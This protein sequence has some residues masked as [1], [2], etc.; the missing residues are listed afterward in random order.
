MMSEARMYARHA[1]YVDIQMYAG[2]G[3]VRLGEA[4]EEEEPDVAMVGALE[5]PAVGVEHLGQA[6]RV[7]AL[8]VGGPA[9]GDGH[10]DLVPAHAAREV[11]EEG[12]EPW[13]IVHCERLGGGN[14]KVGSEVRKCESRNGE[15]THGSAKART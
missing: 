8:E 12:C 7:E 14:A 6:V 9:V 11:L 15:I 5:R 4:A 10:V 3:V 1:G 2:L 13:A